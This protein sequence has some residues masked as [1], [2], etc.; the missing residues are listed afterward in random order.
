M[1][2]LV[3]TEEEL[4]RDHPD[5]AP[6]VVAGRRMHGGFH[7]DGSYQPPRALV[8][9][10]ALEAWTH[11]LIERGGQ[12]LNADSSLLGGT[13]LPTVEQSRVLLRNGLGQTFWNSLTITGKIEARGRLLA[14]IEFPALAPHIVDDISMMAIGHL[15][16]GLLKA[17]G[18]DEGGVADT[19]S[20]TGD[21][22]IG[23][24]DQMWFV[25][26]DLAFGP[27]AFPDV[28][29]PVNIA[30][31]EVGIRV[32]PEVAPEVEGLL[33]LLMNLLVIEFRAEIGFADTQALLRTPELFVDRR[34]QAEEAAEIVG[35]IRTDE[36]IHV[37]SLCL[38]L[39]ECASM[40]FRTVDGGTIAGS[41]L[42]ERFWSGLVRWATVE[43]P[44]LAAEVQR[45]LLH[46]RVQEHPAAD[47]VWAQFES[48]A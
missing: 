15:G 32:M 4:M 5:L 17:H 2:A 23:A 34:A 46:S 29:P 21:G 7:P 42:I 28:E 41:E 3:Y 9:V 19:F 1:T 6:H 38:Y 14:E 26:R 13:R 43:Q 11:A 35:R 48:A 25:A 22:A 31:P 44:A 20:D 39:G 8:R 24:H 33:S 18:W 40:A 30:R 12:P 16:K 36:E 10:P 45:N 37:S 27:D 47:E